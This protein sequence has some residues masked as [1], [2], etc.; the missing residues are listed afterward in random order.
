[1]NPSYDHEEIDIELKNNEKM[2]QKLSNKNSKNYERIK[3]KIKNKNQKK[4]RKLEQEKI[5]KI[6]EYSLLLHQ[7]ISN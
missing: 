5:I 4:N 1:M 6:S 7:L 3:Q 2:F